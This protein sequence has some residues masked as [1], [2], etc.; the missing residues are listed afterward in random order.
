LNTAV[1]PRKLC[2]SDSA[3]KTHEVQAVLEFAISFFTSSDEAWEDQLIEAVGG[4]TGVGDNMNLAP[5]LLIGAGD[6]IDGVTST[7]NTIIPVTAA[8]GPL[9]DKVKLFTEIVDKA[10]EV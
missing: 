2:K 4:V 7:T 10:S 6:F 1:V 3:G 9:L 8:W 5:S